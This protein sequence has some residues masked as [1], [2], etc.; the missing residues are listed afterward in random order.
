MIKIGDF[1]KLAHV[2]VKTLHHYD[3]LGLLEPAH[4][5]R[6]TGY[7]YYTLAQLASLNRILA[8]K[9]LGFS[10]DQ[11]A[12]LMGEDLSLAEIR[13]MLRM[14]QVELAERIELEGARLAQVE[15]RLRQLEGG[16]SPPV[17]EVAVKSVGPQIVLSAR[18]VAARESAV[19]PM[20]E[21]LGVLLQQGLDHARLKPAG[22]W[23]ALMD[24]LPYAESD[25]EVELAVPVKP[26]LGQRVGDWENTPISLRELP[27][28]GDMASVIHEGE[29]GLINQAYT[30]LYAW[31]Q[32]NAFKITGS[33]RE[34]YLPETGFNTIPTKGIHSEFIEVQCPVQR[35][36]I[37]I[38][39][40]SPGTDQKEEIMK[41]KFL[42]KPAMTVVGMPYLGKVDDLGPSFNPHIAEMWGQFMSR[43]KEIKNITGQCNYGACFS[44]PEG[45]APGEFEYVACFEVTEVSDVPE[46]MVV[47]QIPPYRYA[48][49]THKGKLHNLGE[50]Y[51]YIYET[52]LPQAG[53]EPHPDKFDMELYDDRFISD[54]DESEFDILVALKE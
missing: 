19:L 36:S 1:S 43:Y 18:G 9:D 45:G 42:S 31:V 28:V 24:D 40:Y 23:F 22:P 2:T 14:K 44:A 29:Y 52:G 54:S 53:V 34:V 17:Q 30:G 26:R 50:T 7:R 20:R 12:Q 49:F 48:V 21:S 5:D 35:A 10:L 4:I 46:G 27:A 47:R 33:P 51:K 41:P 3:E 37:P 11:V 32:A 39:I 16:G 15:M 25:L 13:G 38:S 6:Y 8:L